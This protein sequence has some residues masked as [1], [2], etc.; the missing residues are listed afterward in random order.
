MDAVFLPFSLQ[1]SEGKISTGT[2]PLLTSY[3]AT[4][5]PFSVGK[6]ITENGLPALCFIVSVAVCEG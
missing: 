1:W 3:S 6:S 2:G 4:H 5:P